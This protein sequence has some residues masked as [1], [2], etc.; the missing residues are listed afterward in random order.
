M[1]FAEYKYFWFM[2]PVGLMIILL[3]RF[4]IGKR[5][6]VR[7]LGDDR[8]IKKLSSTVSLFL[9]K[10]RILILALAMMLIVLAM[11]G[12]QWGYQ[13]EETKTR[14]VDIMVLLDV[15]RSMLADDIKPS[16]LD[17]AKTEIRR[18]VSMLKGDRVGLVIFSGSSIL[19]CPLT[20]D[21]S[22]F[23]LFLQDVNTEMVSHG[24]TDLGK[25]INTAIKSFEGS[26]SKYHVI[27]LIT[28]GEDHGRHTEAAVKALKNS[29]ISLYMMG[30]GTLEGGLIPITKENGT[31][32][33]LKD[34]EG[35]FVN[36][37]L[38]KDTFARIAAITG[39]GAYVKAVPGDEDLKEIYKNG[40]AKLEEREIKSS[41][42]KKYENRYQVAL[43]AAL[44]LLI[45]ESLI[46]ERKKGIEY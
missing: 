6:Q 27:F 1:K 40:I 5:N 13:I 25:A 33:F 12:P 11:A 15:S 10:I 21:Y 17:W 32:G 24:G 46:E 28:D 2:I 19:Q 30:V 31:K 39:S 43:S 20:A 45:M 29:G 23:D 35:N 9:G 34:R 44:I 16:R 42:V 14:G 22:V 7:I 37:K 26:E 36:T 38:E 3:I 18:L 41:T 8:L 4:Y